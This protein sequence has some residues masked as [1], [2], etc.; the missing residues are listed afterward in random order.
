VSQ[1]AAAKARRNLVLQK[2]LEQR[3]VTR[4]EYD[5][6][7][8]EALPGSI[9]PPRE[10]SR[11]PYF[12]TWIK[13]QVVDHFGVAKAFSGGLLI[14]TTLDLDLQALAEQAVAGRLGS[15]GPSAALVAIDNQTGG[16]KAMVGGTDYHE[17]P[18]NLATQGQRQP[19]SAFKAFVLAT[20]LEQ[21]Q[22]AGSMWSSRK[23][24]F[25]VP[26]TRG[27]EKFVVN[28]YENAYLGAASLATATTYSD[29]SVFAEVGIRVGTRKIARL[30][31]Q[32]GIRTPVSTNPAMTL[33]GLRAGVTPLDLA[34]AYTT[35][36]RGGRRVSGSLA[37]SPGGP[38]GL[39]RV[40]DGGQTVRNAPRVRT[41]LP[42]S[43]A[44][45]T[46]EILQSVIRSGTGKAAAIDGFA[47]GKT[48]T[49]ENYGDAW[50]VGYT[51]RFTVAV[52]V[53]YPDSLRP[54]L[55]EFGGKPVAGGTYPALIWHDFIAATI[56]LL[57]RRAEER[58]AR[59]DAKAAKDARR[60]DGAS[61]F[62][63]SSDTPPT[64]APEKNGTAREPRRP[65]K[66]KQP[67]ETPRR[68]REPEPSPI[69][70][71]QPPAAPPPPGSE[72]APATG[73]AAPPAT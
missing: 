42:R 59:L 48:G 24:V 68:D 71:P 22:S 26:G 65:T 64:V 32:M 69:P 10:E 8:L 60:R 12:T 47:A 39:T 55:T 13:Q 63:E 50:F 51:E 62:P 53:G 28:N 3:Y 56:A 1:P 34:H 19:G 73:G 6:G 20:A 15:V 72:P 41:V 37:A 57:E 21:G 66:R 16:V 23:K 7:A 54:M 36:A 45:T 27:Q 35:L 29:N 44:Q 38:V 40:V 33:G 52:W 43:V 49:T 2:M 11:A 70:V 9:R 31:R 30:A 67:G 5:R 61:T 4:A 25:T 17:R 14:R 46:T 58:A 18:F